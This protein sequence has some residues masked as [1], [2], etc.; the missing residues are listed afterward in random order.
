MLRNKGK[1]LYLCKIIVAS[2]FARHDNLARTQSPSTDLRDAYILWH[3]YNI[4]FLF[5]SYIHNNLLVIFLEKITNELFVI[6]TI[7]TRIF[8]NIFNMNFDREK[9]RKRKKEEWCSTMQSVSL[10]NWAHS[11]FPLIHSS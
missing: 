2:A 8:L 10:V 6:F 1:R 3:I 5:I 4:F 9:E 11:I 7:F